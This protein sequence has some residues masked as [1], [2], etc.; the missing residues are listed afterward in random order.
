MVRVPRIANRDIINAYHERTASV[1]GRKD[2]VEPI[3]DNTFTKV[4]PQTRG[5]REPSTD[6]KIEHDKAGNPIV[7]KTPPAKSVVVERLHL[8]W[9]GEWKQ[10]ID[11]FHFIIKAKT[12]N[13]TLKLFFSGNRYCWVYEADTYFKRSAI[14]NSKE[15]AELEFNNGIRYI[16]TEVKPLPPE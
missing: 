6:Y 12:A 16:K 7:V 1:I 10:G 14:F 2:R 15:A 8:L 11:D 13:Y 4:V 9:Q 3:I 5:L